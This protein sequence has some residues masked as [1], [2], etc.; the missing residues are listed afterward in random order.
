MTK[1]ASLSL[2]MLIVARV[3]AAQNAPAPTTPT[4]TPDFPVVRVGM[5]AYTQYDVELENR[6]AYNAFDLTRG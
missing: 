3:A 4:P 2:A 1:L 6:G 5:V